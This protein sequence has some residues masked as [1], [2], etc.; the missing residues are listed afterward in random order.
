MQG[1]GRAL[2]PLFFIGYFLYLHFK[3]FPLSRPPLQKPPSYL[4]ASMRMLP[5]HLLPPSHPGIPLH[6]AIEHLQ[7]QGLCL[8]LMSNKAI[9]CHIC[10]RSHGSLHVYILVGGPVPGSSGGSGQLT[11]LLSPWGCKPPKLLQFLL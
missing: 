1:S 10:C 7:A 5:L 9:L 2:L 8:P 11:L 4:P 6:W 3:Y